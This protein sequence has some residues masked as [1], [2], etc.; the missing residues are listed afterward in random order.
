MAFW[1]GREG[2]VEKPREAL[3]F[4]WE[5]APPPDRDLALFTLV[6]SSNS[7]ASFLETEAGTFASFQKVLKALYFIAKAI[8][9]H[10]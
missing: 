1:R 8:H 10:C 7:P 6:G 3:E 2:P 9:V 4:P 5:A